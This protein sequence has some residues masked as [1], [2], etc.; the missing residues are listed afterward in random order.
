[1]GIRRCSVKVKFRFTEKK[2]NEKF[3]GHARNLQ[4]K[5]NPDGN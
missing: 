5:E 1:M 2:L 4:E 3:E